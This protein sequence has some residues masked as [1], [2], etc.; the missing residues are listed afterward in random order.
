MNKIGLKEQQ[1]IILAALL[2]VLIIT[3]I[4]GISIYLRRQKEMPVVSKVPS[5][6]VAY[7]IKL[8]SLN[9]QYG[10][11]GA[12][13]NLSDILFPC[14]PAKWIDRIA[15]ETGGVFD[16]RKMHSGNTYA[17][18]IS[19]DSTHRT[20]Y[21]IYEIN[22]IEFVVYD[23][24]DSLRVY[25]D[26]KKVSIKMRAA[27]GKIT[28]SLWKTFEDLDLDI[29]LETDLAEIFAWTIDFYGIQNG[30]AFKVIYEETY[31]DDRM[32]GINRILSAYF[33]SNYKDYYAF[34]FEVLGKKE[35]FDENGQSLQRSFL[36][37]PLRFSRISSRFSHSRMHPVLR[38]VRPHFGVDYAA[39]RGT[40]VEALGDGKVTEVGRKGG[41]GRFI[42]IRHNPVYST[43]YAHLSGYAKNLKAGIHVNQG[44]VIGFVGSSGL[45]TGPHLDFRVYKNGMPVDPLHLESPRSEPIP[46][47]ALEKYKLQVARWRPRL[48][49][50][51]IN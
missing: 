45:A 51:K 31:V 23:F 40:A 46:V 16:V 12:N 20:L 7:K 27:A 29:R 22:S 11:V 50:L 3:L 41:Y 18:I 24:R 25:R 2:P 13:Q 8:D 39:P 1:W 34:L 28:S 42:S 19:K 37:A 26:K 14:I 5:E 4:F 36:K 10:K 33:R 47:S 35:Y 44:E 38:I 43:S 9:I 48:D 6:H 49:S 32:I 17:R 21:F 15:K 30:D